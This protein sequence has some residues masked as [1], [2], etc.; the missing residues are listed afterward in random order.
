MKHTTDYDILIAGA[1]P[2][3]TH[4]A[5][6]LAR[7]G[8]RVALLDRREFPRKKPCG[9][10]LSPACLPM[11][12]DLGLLQE[13]LDGGAQ[14]VF[15]MRLH[16][17]S[18]RA[19]GTYAKL[20]RFRPPADDEAGFGLGMR[21]EVLDNQAVR[22]AQRE[23]GISVLL[24]WRVHE[25][26]LSAEGRVTGVSVTNPDGERLSLTAR[27]VI[28]AD[29]LHSRIARGLDWAT[30]W[31]GQERFALVARFRGV[32]GP[33]EA[34]VHI[35]DGGDY[36]AACP[37]DDGL[38]TANLI[39]DKEALNGGS[40]GGL[41]KLFRSKLEQAPGLGERLADGDLDEP[42]VA[43]GPLRSATR[44]CT[45]PGVALVGDACGFVDPF[46]G[47]GLF[48]AMRG[49]QMLARAVD[50]SL[51]A[52]HREAAAMRRYAWDRRREFSPRYGFA[53]LLQRG[54]KCKRVPDRVIGLLGRRAALCDLLLG[55]TG[56]YVPPLG[57]LSPSVWRT[58]LFDSR[59]AGR[60]EA[61]RLSG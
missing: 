15:G 46:T 27:F 57:L 44:R 20:G 56:D 7:A 39:V 9:E 10:F 21:R 58:I 5:L 14:R 55:L 33:P 40:N 6:I 43:L 31:E 17:P 45:G 54:L 2:A 11:L 29:G 1:G 22:A 48:F 53:K 36:F 50:A 52:P 13:L 25:P 26:T 61:S 60:T 37:I 18:K 34:E 35:L 59:V 8:W 42:I 16:A 32:E 12:E 4:T 24:G 51:R 23:P 41:E 19:R 30:R 28:G 38:Y 49:A 3:G 47:E